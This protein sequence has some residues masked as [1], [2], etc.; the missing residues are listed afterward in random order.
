VIFKHNFFLFLAGE[1][2][3]G[4]HDSRTPSH[5]S[6]S[7]FQRRDLSRQSSDRLPHRPAPPVPVPGQKPV[8][9]SLHRAQKQSTELPGTYEVSHKK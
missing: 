7:H 2:E 1:V 8:R 5:V 3:L 4:R 9:R 6:R